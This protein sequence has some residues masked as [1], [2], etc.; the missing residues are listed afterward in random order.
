[1]PPAAAKKISSKN[2]KIFIFIAVG[3]AIVTLVAFA[4]F[5][6][7]APAIAVQTEKI[8]QRNLTEIVTANGKIQPVVQV[9]I[10]PEVSGEITELNVK[11][12]QPVKK[13]DLLLK[14]KPDFYTAALKQAQASYASS[15]SS[16]N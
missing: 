6:K 2:R 3:L 15:L 5:K 4:V 10:S 12:G 1:Q 14:I 9:T 11:E 7:R 13:G 16:R 8:A